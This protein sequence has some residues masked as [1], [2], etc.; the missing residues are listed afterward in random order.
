MTTPAPLDLLER[1]RRMAL[2]RVKEKPTDTPSLL[3]FLRRWWCTYYKRPSKDPLLLEY[4]DVELILEFFERMFTDNE[5]E[6]VKA[7]TELLMADSQ[8]D[9]EAWLK[10]QM[11]ES[12]MSEDEMKAAVTKKSSGVDHV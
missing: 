1:I 8:D 4:T 6:R 7:E 10:E 9:D 3:R 12:Y 5:K 11:G 2:E